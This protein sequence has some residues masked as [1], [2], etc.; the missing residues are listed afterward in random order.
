[1]TI[2]ALISPSENAIT[3]T[4][5]LQHRERLEGKIHYMYGGIIPLNA[6]NGKRLIYKNPIK[7]LSAYISGKAINLQFNEKENA[8][9]NYLRNNKIEVVLAEYGH[10]GANVMMVCKKLQIP[11]LVHFHGHDAFL[12]DLLSNYK[13]RYKEMFSYATTIV[14]VSNLMT[15]KLISLGCP[16]EKILYNPY[17]PICDFY[18][19][20][21]KW[22]GKTFLSVGRFVEKKSPIITLSAFK[23]TLTTHPD[24]KLIMV[25]DGPLL[26]VCKKLVKDWG[27]DKSIQFKGA[28]PHRKIIGYFSECIAF[29]QHSITPPSGDS[30]GTPVGILEAGAAGLPVISTKHAGISDVVIH[31]ETGYLVDEFDEIE[32]ANY[33]VKIASDINLAKKLGLSARKRVYDHFNLDRH[34]SLLNIEV[35]RAISLKK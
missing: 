15:K 33:M 18:S 26:K 3:E 7:R 6:N 23:R 14:S 32:M 10:A 17:G 30:E 24:A 34:I 28:I 27:I 1:M 5:I 35:K 11:L 21:N 13:E 12:N 8:L 19:L 16:S 2:L 20:I 22:E 29:V 4:F 25:G 9:Y 31:M